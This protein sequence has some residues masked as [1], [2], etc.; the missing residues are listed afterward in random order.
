MENIISGNL[1][2]NT[3]NDESGKRYYAIRVAFSEKDIMTIYRNTINELMEELPEIISYAINAR[4]TKKM[5][6]N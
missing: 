2:I 5:S 3:L 1:D 6:T 4:I